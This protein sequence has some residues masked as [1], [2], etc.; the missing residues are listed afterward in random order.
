[1]IKRRFKL[2]YIALLAIYSWNELPSF[3]QSVQKEFTDSLTLPKVIA[4]VSQNYPSVKEAEEALNAADAKISL[5]RSGYYPDVSASASYSRIGPVPSLTFPGLGTFQFYP[6][7]NYSAAINYKQNILDFGKT[8][9]SISLENQNKN[10]AQQSLVQVKQKISILAIN[11][12][13]SLLYLQDAISIK[14]TEIQNLQEHLKFIQ[15][16]EASGSATQFEI[17]TTQV[18]ISTVENQKT[19]LKTAQKVQIA[20][21]NSLL[22]QSDNTVLSVKNELKAVSTDI[23]AD[24]LVSFAFRNRD[25]LKI[26]NGKSALAKLRYETVKSQNNPDLSV[27]AS[28]GGKNGYIP[29]LNTVKANYVAGISL[30]IPI[31]DANRTKYNLLQVKSS[32]QSLDFE[33]E[34]LR[35]TITNEVIESEANLAAS[36]QKI[37]EFELQLAHADKAFSLAQINYKEGTITNLD[38]LDATTAVAESRLLLLKA[39]IDYT[40]STY[41]VKAAIGERL[42]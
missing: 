34:T 23:P 19:D 16:K 35:R 10:I 24:S 18:K 20:L 40:V 30:N 33:T 41:K 38:L 25:E 29:N 13:Y 39:Q 15:K 27:F 22:G 36:Q 9:K 37:D 31:F 42:Y 5:A 12:F 21:M 8:S 26:E 17:L 32:M 1:M 3:E 6:A 14:D 11:C 28:A 2:F 4:E 7:D